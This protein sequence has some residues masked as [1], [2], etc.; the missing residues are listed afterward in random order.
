MAASLRMVKVSGYPTTDTM[1][2]SV[3][4][5][6]QY[7]GKYY[8]HFEVYN[9]STDTLYRTYDGAVFTMPANGSQYDLVKTLD[10][11]QP[12][13]SYYVVA[14]LWNC[15]YSTP[16]DRL[17]IDEPT[18]RFTTES[19]GEII[20]NYYDE[21]PIGTDSGQSVTIRSSSKSGWTFMGWSIAT[22][23][24]AIDYE[25]GKTVSTTGSDDV[26]LDLYAVYKKETEIP[27][28]F[29]LGAPGH[30][31]YNTRTKIQYLVHTDE[32]NY[33]TDYYNSIKLPY[34]SSE[35]T[36]ITTTEPKRE[37]EA[38][39]WHRTA[40]GEKPDYSPGQVIDCK[41]IYNSLLA[42]YSNECS[43]TYNSNSGSGSMS[44]Q[45]GTAY[46][47][48][49]SNYSSVTFTVKDC[50]FTPPSGKKF[51]HW[52]SKSDGSGTTYHPGDS[53]PTNYNNTFYAIWVK[54]R[55]SNWSWPSHTADKPISSGSSMNYIQSGTTVTPTPLTAAEWLA[56]M[57]RIKEFYAYDNGKTVNSTYWN[58]AVNGV[59]SGSPMTATQVN[60]AR[61]LISQLPIQTTLPS[62]VSSGG[63][64]TAAFINGLKNSLNSIP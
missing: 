4:F 36:T 54:A 5:T 38:I 64:I 42:I 43:I 13:T 45:T 9:R 57:N 44:K 55:P 8:V 19:V 7:P 56:F 11:L 29:L 40:A 20:I 16:G 3:D 10:K 22:Y 62:A 61:Y 58:N 39:G 47:S 27:C 31:K 34:F 41:E 35:N 24:I 15:T 28:Y 30:L 59:K 63:K 18:K 17:P 33:S 32:Y 37:W 23:T 12:G 49:Y 50:T 6:V 52:N 26:I 1:K 25:P 2:V 21:G 14:S 53:I 48:A 46:Y 51:S 60:S